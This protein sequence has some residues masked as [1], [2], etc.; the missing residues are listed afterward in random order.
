MGP[1]AGVRVLEFEAIGPGPFCGMMLAD[2]GADVLLVDRRDNPGAGLGVSREFDIMLRG[3]RSV[4]LDLK[5]ADGIAA[6]LLLADK[7]DAI[8]EG[9][10]P[11]VMERLGLGPEV[12]LA[13]NPGLV[14]GRMTGWGQDGPLAAR[15]GHDINYIALSGALHGIGRAGEAPVP[16]L[17]LVGDFGGGG[18]LLAFGIACGIIEARGSGRGQ[19][20]DAAMVD[21]ASLLSTMF[22]G[23]LAGGYWRDER[24]ANVIDSGAPWYDTYRTRDG[25]YV[26]IGAIESKFY[27]ELLERL[28]LA[29]R[30]LPHQ[31]DRARWPELRALFT[32]AFAAKTRDEWCAVFEGS[33]ACFAPVLTFGEAR[34]HPQSAARNGFVDVGGIAQPAPAPRFGRTPGAVTGAPPARGAGGREALGEWGFGPEEV[35]RLV[36]LGVGFA[37]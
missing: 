19:V 11:G 14:Y 6:A 10:R 15:A 16:P 35:E 36:A 32:A 12:M 29:D 21:G 26:A 17:N 37:R 18:L 24:G 4:M 27:G 30:P 1:L 22:H 28:G 34:E 9:F 8:I 5:S 20:V 33:D 2:M 13:G 25:Q 7:A 23:L 3:R 31:Y